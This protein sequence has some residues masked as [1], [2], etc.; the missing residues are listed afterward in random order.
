M[1]PDRERP[2]SF[3]LLSEIH[4][5]KSGLS[6]Y[7]DLSREIESML[8]QKDEQIG[9]TIRASLKDAHESEHQD[10]AEDY[11]WDIH[12]YQD[13]F[14]LLHR[15]AMFLT[16]YNYFEHFLTKLCEWIGDEIKSRI[17]LRDLQ[18]RGVE[19]A[20]LFLKLVPEFE[21]SRI[22][23]VVL[24][25]RGANLLRNVIVHAG[26]VLPVELND[27]LNQFVTSHPHLSGK[28]GNA[29]ALHKEFVA[30]F[31]GT[32]DQ[33]FTEVQEEMQR[34][35]DRTWRGSTND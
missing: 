25:L 23:A 14:P 11:A 34:Y 31:A 17:R 19:R 5:I 7:L 26:S 32:L 9:D 24:D 3:E 33:F 13:V 29:V 8:A 22:P 6:N 30:A 27:R 35:M 16:V 2:F 20:F 28:P 12:K 15:E 21:F 10:I 18:G 4:W 1:E